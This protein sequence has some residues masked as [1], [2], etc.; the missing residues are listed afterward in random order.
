MASYNNYITRHAIFLVTKIT[1][2]D[3]LL[4]RHEIL[5]YK[6]I[7]SCFLTLFGFKGN[8]ETFTNPYLI[9]GE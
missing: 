9:R 1:Q 2:A 5:H 6:D 8:S 3:R 4:E 7:R